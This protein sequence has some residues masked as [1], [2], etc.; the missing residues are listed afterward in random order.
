[1]KINFQEEG[2]N[3]VIDFQGELD[4]GEVDWLLRYALLNLLHK[5]ML[6]YQLKEK[7]INKPSLTLVDVN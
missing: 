5:G 2:P 6:P 1:M 4:A 7:V 3:G